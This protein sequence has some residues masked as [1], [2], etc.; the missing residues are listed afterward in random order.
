LGP[1]YGDSLVRLA[2][3]CNVNINGNV[4]RRSGMNLFGA[5]R[6][7]NS[8]WLRSLRN[9]TSGHENGVELVNFGNM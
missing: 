3:G 9:D 5:L 2:A 8:T 1:F 6:S 4:I 7:Y